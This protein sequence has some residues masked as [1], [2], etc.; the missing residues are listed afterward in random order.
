MLSRHP[1]EDALTSFLFVQNS[2]FESPDDILG[3]AMLTCCTLPQKGP[4]SGLTAW[5]LILNLSFYF[6]GVMFFP[7]VIIP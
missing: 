5:Y 3:E 2:V 7:I 4:V 6:K 1:I